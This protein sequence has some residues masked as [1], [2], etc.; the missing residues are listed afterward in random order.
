[1]PADAA[2]VRAVG[3]IGGRLNTVSSGTSPTGVTSQF[4]Y[5]PSLH[6]SNSHRWITSLRSAVSVVTSREHTPV[7]SRERRSDLRVDHRG[8]DVPMAQPVF[9]VGEIPSGI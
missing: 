3:T 9:H 6:S 5:A 4:I 2:H 8:G 7:T 1:M